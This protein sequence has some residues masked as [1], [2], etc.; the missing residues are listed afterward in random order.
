LKV[1]FMD[2]HSTGTVTETDFS[3]RPDARRFELFEK[4]RALSLGLGKA[5][6]YALELGVDRIWKRIQFLSG[7]LRRRLEEIP[8]VTVHDRGDILCGIVTFSVAG[9]D[10]TQVKK[11]LAERKINVSIGRASSTLLY[12]N[13]N[14][15]VSVLR[16]SV[17]YYN[18]EEEIGLLCAT[19]QGK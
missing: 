13:K 1:L 8:G 2:D 15:L 11:E 5:I 19:L 14:H 9:K 12:M 18:T 17:H 6:D 10:T 4:S 3:L 7:I 16:A